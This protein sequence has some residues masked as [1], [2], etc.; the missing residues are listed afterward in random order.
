MAPSAMNLR[1]IGA[2]K[3]VWQASSG[4]GTPTIVETQVRRFNNVRWTPVAS[5]I[6]FE[7]DDSRVNK[8][9]VT[10]LD[11]DITFHEND[12]AALSTI[13]S[14]AVV[15]TPPTGEAERTNW[16]GDDAAG[17]VGACYLVAKAEDTVTKTTVTVR[18]LIHLATLNLVSPPALN[19][20]A[21]VDQ[22]LRISA[23]KTP[24]DILGA[25][26]PGLTTNEAAE[27]GIFFS[28]ARMS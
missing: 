4:G 14:R 24:I 11:A 25:A 7:G 26:L 19:Y 27:G 6:P 20:G 10:G 2:R 5:D 22:V 12:I 15:P 21:R 28:L 18:V 23:Q 1:L 13:F 8:H 17:A 16:L 9:F 3:F